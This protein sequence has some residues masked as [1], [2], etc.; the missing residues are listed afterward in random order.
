MGDKRAQQKLHK[1]QQ[2]VLFSLIHYY[3]RVNLLFTEKHIQIVLSKSL[4][5]GLF[6]SIGIMKREPRTIYKAFEE[7]E[8]RKYIEYKNHAL[9]IPKKGRKFYEKKMREMKPYLAVI[10]LPEKD[11]IAAVKR[12]QTVLA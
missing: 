9:H 7:L 6:K 12:A 3:E 2:I 1:T 4:F 10:E 8:K 11:L 5:I